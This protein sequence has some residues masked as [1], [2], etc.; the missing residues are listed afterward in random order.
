M[1]TTYRYQ[2]DKSSRKFQC[3]SCGKKKFVRYK[4]TENQQYLALA[5]G[6]CDR[7]MSC[8]YF[9]NPYEDL[10]EKSNDNSWQTVSLKSPDNRPATQPKLHPL[11]NSVLGK[12]ITHADKNSFMEYLG[13]HAQYPFPSAV[14]Q[15]LA[16]LYLLGTISK[17]YRQGAVT[18]PFIDIENNI[19]AIQVKLFDKNNNTLATDFIHSICQKEFIKAGNAIPEWLRLYLKN[20]K[21]VSC[22]FGEHLLHSYPN[23]PIALVEAPKTAL[24]GTL[25]FGFPDKPE[26]FLWLAVYN[27]SSLSIEKCK[28]LKGRKV[29]LFPDLSPSGKAFHLWSQK[30]EQLN[31]TLPGSTFIVSEL[32]EVHAQTQE[33]EKGYDL[34]D[35]LITQDWRAFQKKEEYKPSHSAVTHFIDSNPR[36]WDCPTNQYTTWAIEKEPTVHISPEKEHWDIEGLKTFFESHSNMPT[37]IICDQGFHIRDVKKFVASHF[38]ILERNLNNP[39]FRPYFDRL[40]KLKTKLEKD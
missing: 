11:P 9:K 33:R 1:M 21:K 36:R 29:V 10:K 6:R 5:Y 23:N 4:D 37:S 3:P 16:K 27:I 2:L 28:V 24:Y 13:Q 34:A 18:F 22:L 8:G 17:G 15:K 26:N 7:E 25:Y 38:S 31:E 40:Q 14:L 35:Y 12:T 20:D 32:L 19:R 30:A 39:T